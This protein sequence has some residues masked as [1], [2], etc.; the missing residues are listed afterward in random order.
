MPFAASSPFVTKH[1]MSK[2]GQVGLLLRDF[3]SRH[4]I[5]CWLASFIYYKTK[6]STLYPSL[7]MSTTILLAHAYTST[8]FYCPIFRFGL[9]LRQKGTDSREHSHNNP[10]WSRSCPSKGDTWNY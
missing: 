8:H 1:G 10:T 9:Y 2:D 3:G 4:Y 5:D 6:I 7:S